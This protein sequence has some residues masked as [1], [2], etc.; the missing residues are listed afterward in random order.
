MRHALNAAGWIITAD[1]SAGIGEK[2]HDIVQAPD[3]LVGKLAARVALFE[4]W[5]AGSEPE[6]VVIQNFSGKTQWFRYM[7]GLRELFEEAGM[8][9]PPVSG[10]SETNMATMQSGIGVVMFG[11]QR[12]HPVDWTD[13]NW[14]VYGVPLVGE[15]VLTKQE[16][17]ADLGKIRNALK[18]NVIN[19][20]W[21]VGSQGIAHEVRQLT[22]RRI[23]VSAG[24]LE[25]EVSGGP[26]ACVLIG[27]ALTDINELQQHLGEAVVPLIFSE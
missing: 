13:L 1:N 5:T 8:E 11:R 19:R 10:S 22:G 2:V 6:A 3:E 12:M 7:N 21:P 26:A 23:A 18:G 20:V 14:Y 16:L 9:M 24:E 25:L 17:M 27:S 4:Q 15:E